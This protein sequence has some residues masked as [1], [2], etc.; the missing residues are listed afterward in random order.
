ML[1]L[2]LLLAAAVPAAPRGVDSPEAREQARLCGERSREPGV[3][4]CRR[5]LE[6]GLSKPRATR[7]W[8]E[9]APKLASLGRW[10]ETVEAYRE[11]AQREPGDAELRYRLAA[12]MLHGQGQ[13]EAAAAEL[14]A[15]LILAPGDPRIWAELGAALNALGRAT[16]SVAA[17]EEALKLDPQCLELRPAAR[18]V[19]EASRRGERWP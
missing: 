4:A 13:A 19:L 7:V 17:F 15:A 18:L 5:A 2:A 16:E 3:E 14:R 6:L 1:L 10:D 11:L 12:A 9:L 8:R